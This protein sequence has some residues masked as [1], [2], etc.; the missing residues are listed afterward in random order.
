MKTIETTNEVKTMK[1]RQHGFTLVE[2]AIVL[3]I[4]GL[5]LGGVM[6]GRAMIENAKIK[7]LENNVNGNIAAVNTFMD[8]YRALPGD[9][10][11]A[12]NR[13]KAGLTD[14]DGNGRIEG[15]ERYSFWSHLAA[16]G[17]VS[18]DF[19]GTSDLPQHTYGG[20]ILPMRA[21]I[22]GKETHWFQYANVPVKAAAQLDI[23][24]DDGKPKSGAI[25]SDTADCISGT[26]YQE[27][28]EAICAVYAEF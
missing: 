26:D 20:T 2:I 24:L 17:I 8:R 28:A 6:K 11:K 10:K 12:S 27:T 25:Q 14:G 19:D 3:V 18:G 13:I 22:N 1:R 4:I 7:N 16:A 21:K 5:L 23:D 15:G 9:F